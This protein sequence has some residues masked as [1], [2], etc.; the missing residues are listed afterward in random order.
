MYTFY[1]MSDLNDNSSTPKCPRRLGLRRSGSVFKG[2]YTKSVTSVRLTKLEDIVQTPEC[3][4]SKAPQSDVKINYK[5]LEHESKN[6]AKLLTDS[7]HT[8]IASTGIQSRQAVST[9]CRP[10]RLS[11]SKKV[12]ERMTKKRL[13]FHMANE[14]E[15]KEV[16]NQVEDE[17]SQMETSQLTK[18]QLLKQI[19]IARQE[20]K[21]R[22]EH[23]K[24]S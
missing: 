6:P 8:P 7:P 3:V 18:D 10:Y 12:R 4:R 9:N 21:A 24:K 20:L 14:V 22:E 16:A 1:K 17:D 23:V 13:E 15:K 11:L 5:Q 19:E 2:S